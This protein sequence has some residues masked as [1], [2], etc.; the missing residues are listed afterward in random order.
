MQNLDD[1]FTVPFCFSQMLTLLEGSIKRDYLSSHFETT[2]ELLPSSNP[3]DNVS[4]LGAVTV[5]PW[6]PQTT[7]AVALRLLE[8][9]ASISYALDQRVESQEDKGVGEFMVSNLLHFM[10]YELV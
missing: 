9:D 3:S 1:G 4:N 6:I 10:I 2:S 7:A 5:L 8:F